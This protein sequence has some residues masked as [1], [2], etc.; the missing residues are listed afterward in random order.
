MTIYI[1]CGQ[2]LEHPYENRGAGMFWCHAKQTYV[3]QERYN[4]CFCFG[5]RELKTPRLEY[6]GES[7]V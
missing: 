2:E 4:H 3:Q 6:K 7:D 1:K 5:K